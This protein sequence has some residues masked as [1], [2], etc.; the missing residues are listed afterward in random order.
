M[1]LRL[2]PSQ[3]DS[4]Q[5]VVLPPQRSE[6]LTETETPRQTQ[7]DPGRDRQTPAETDR[8]RQR[9][10]DPGRDRQTPAET[11]RPRQRQTDPGRDR[12]TPA[13]TD[14]PRQR[15]TDP[16]RDRQTPAETSAME[17]KRL[18][19]VS[20]RVDAHEGKKKRES[21]RVK[22]EDLSNEPLEEADAPSI[23]LAA[24]MCSPDKGSQWREELQHFRKDHRFSKKVLL[25][26]CLVRRIIAWA[27]PKAKGT[28]TH[29]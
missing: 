6:A 5:Q 1:V 14:R 10:T 25:N 16:G 13:E 26:C 18:H 11:D 21:A 17:G 22:P 20:A 7:T 24:R 3:V 2:L 27:T 9:Q 29:S 4:E 28:M 15:Q 12:Q 8:P 23:V 19:T